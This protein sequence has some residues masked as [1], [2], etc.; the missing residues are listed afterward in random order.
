MSLSH[1][2][3]TIIHG[4]PALLT[5]GVPGARAG[6]QLLAFNQ[7][8]FAVRNSIELKSRE[9]LADQ[10]IPTRFSVD[11]Q[12][13]SPPVSWSNVPEEAKSLVLL[14]EDPDA[15]L[16]NPFVHWLAFNVAPHITSLPEAISPQEN[17]LMHQG[18]NSNLKIG[19]AGMAPP[20]GDT[21]HHYHFQMFALDEPLALKDGVGRSA[22]LAAMNGHVLAKGRIIGT[23]QRQAG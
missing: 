4:T 8:N 1:N 12:N 3:R 14:V 21:P 19:W 23:F 11:G 7:P 15:P 20:K 10:E 16:P 18:K 22:L 17:S 6:D 9:F 13:L 2:L 5:G